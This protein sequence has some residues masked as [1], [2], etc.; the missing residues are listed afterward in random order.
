MRRGPSALVAAAVAT[1]VAVVIVA[2]STH[3]TSAWHLVLAIVIAPCACAASSAAGRRLGGSG[4]GIATSVVYSM[5]P[6]LGIAY[7]LTSYR[8]TFVHGALPALVGLESPGWLALGAAVALGLALL[9]KSLLGPVGVIAIFAA[10]AAWGLDPLTD[11][12][13]GIHETGWSVALIEWVF[14]AGVIGAAT[15]SI[16]YAAA[17][18]GWLVLAV[19]R[20]AHGG[21]GSDG[22]FWRSLSLAEPA[23]AVL[24]TS[25]ALLVPAARPV[26]KVVHPADAP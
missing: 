2:V 4:F 10:G 18:T 19:L 5:L 26:R 7:S 8:H 21:Y 22:D 17:L 1:V 3:Q 16:R 25:L 9:P 20:A 14:V 6:L 15:R 11:V 12:R 23:I 24:L 13:N